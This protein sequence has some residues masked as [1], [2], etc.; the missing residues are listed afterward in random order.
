MSRSIF[1]AAISLW[2]NDLCAKHAS[3]STTCL[4]NCSSFPGSSWPCSRFSLHITHIQIEYCLYV[5]IY[6]LCV[7]ILELYL[8]RKQLS[9]ITTNALD[10]L[11]IHFAQVIISEVLV[12][13]YTIAIPFYIHT[14]L[15]DITIH[16]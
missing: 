3:P 7:N 11:Y 10:G 1:L 4:Q 16:M 8:S 15:K 13:N 5:E 6:V 2:I 12:I 14:Y 9:Y